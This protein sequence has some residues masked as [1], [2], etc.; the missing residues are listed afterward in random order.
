ML[1]RPSCDIIKINKNRP[2]IVTKTSLKST[3]QLGSIWEPT[4]LHF[5]RVWGAK[6]GQDGTKSLQKSI[7]KLIKKIITFWIAL[8]IDFY[9]FWPPTWPPR[10]GENVWI[11]ALGTLLGASWG[12]L[13]AQMAPRPLQNEILD[14]FCPQL[15]RF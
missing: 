10:G 13:G 7:F 8:G 14:D 11:F 1:L 4:C 15:A 5:G 9:G 12:D 2:K 6:L 3:P